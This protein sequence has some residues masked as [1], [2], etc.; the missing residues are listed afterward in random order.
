MDSWRDKTK[1]QYAV[2]H[3]RWNTYCVIK[4]IEPLNPK[5][6]DVLSFLVTQFDLGLRYSALNSVRS[7]L[8]CILPMFEGFSF[9]THPTTLRL[10]KSFYNKR[11]PQARYTEM[12]N[13]D[14][15]LDYLREKTPLDKLSLKELTLKFVML[16]M[17]ATCCRQQKLCLLKRSN[18]KFQSNGS[19]KI[20]ID[21]LQKHSTRGKSLEVLTL[22]PFT[23]DRS[24]CVVTNLKTYVSKT[25]QVSNAG[26]WLLCSFKPPYNKVGTQTIA[27]WIKCTM[28]NAGI[29]VSIFKAHSTRGSS[30]SHLAKMGTPLSEILDKGNWSHES[31]FKHFYLRK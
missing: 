25:E 4:N 5:F 31:T 18:I 29:D 24:I 16:F 2:Y 20:V 8:S 6:N 28:Q 11:P 22:K 1:T 27:R 12:W 15:V 21:E 3:R 26:D 19:V 13:P 23:E 17:L 30:A 10:L 7:A 9:G 14:I